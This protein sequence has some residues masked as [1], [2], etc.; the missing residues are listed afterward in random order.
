MYEYLYLY[1]HLDYSGH[2]WR[3]TTKTFTIEKKNLYN[4]V[5]SVQYTSTV[6]I[7]KFSWILSHNKN[8]HYHAL[9]IWVNN[10]YT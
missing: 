7:T 6:Q 1:H 4:T 9:I 2:S 10:P 3:L 8:T 5:Q